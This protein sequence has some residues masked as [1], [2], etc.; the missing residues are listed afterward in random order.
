MHKPAG[1]TS[2]DIVDTA[3]RA[4]G[5]TRIGH[6]GTLDPFA[7]GV[8]VLVVGRATR[9]GRYASSWTKAYDGVIRL[10]VATATDDV[11]GAVVATSELWHDL[12]AASVADALAEVQAEGRQQPPAFSAVKV[13]GVRAYRR[14]RRGEV[15]ALAARPVE[16]H[17]LA[18]TRFEPPLVQFR[19]VVGP[20]TY[21]RGIARDLGQALGC[22][23][24]LVELRRT[25][26]GPLRL[27]DAIAPESVTPR[28]VRTAAVLVGDL[29]RRALTPAE[30]D[31]AVH[32]RPIAAGPDA[33]AEGPVALFAG[34]ELVAVA[35]LEGG[36]LRPRVVVAA[37]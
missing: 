11:T 13:G 14:A 31:D 6:L 12:S 35:D 27:R 24:H 2:H 29:P 19:A 1:P 7:S 37:A 30:R 34:D 9:L 33:G 3:R 8:L 17:E 10:G 5:V 36:R 25:A 26:V 21:L 28:A 22:G 20:G 32:G 23:A 16:V 15:V 18:V 4:L